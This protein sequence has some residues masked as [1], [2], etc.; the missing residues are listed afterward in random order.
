MLALF[1]WV[2]WGF[3]PK[4]FPSGQSPRDGGEDFCALTG[5][6]GNQT[7]NTEPPRAPD[8]SPRLVTPPYMSI[9]QP[10][11]A[12]SKKRCQDTLTLD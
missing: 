11:R 9:S 10:Q 3:S 2:T 7:S 4:A 5:P 8:F 1:E 6:V 12:G